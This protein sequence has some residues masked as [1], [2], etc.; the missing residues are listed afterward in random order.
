MRRIWKV[1]TWLLGFGPMELVT[2]WEGMDFYVQ[3]R[4]EITKD[5][6]RM[7]KCV[8]TYEVIKNDGLNDDVPP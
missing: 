7:Y 6:L 8:C 2:W 4:D 5:T 1:L 3:F